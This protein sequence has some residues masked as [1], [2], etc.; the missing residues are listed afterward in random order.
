MSSANPQPKPSALRQA[1]AKLESGMRDLRAAIGLGAVEIDSKKSELIEK[2]LEAMHLEGQRSQLFQLDGPTLHA[3]CLILLERS[4][5]RADAH[6]WINEQLG[7]D[8][9]VDDNAFY[10]FASNFYSYYARA[11]RGEFNAS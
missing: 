6:R 1:F 8:A 10:R 11:R 4:K 2:A 3:L 5:T 7:D 9:A